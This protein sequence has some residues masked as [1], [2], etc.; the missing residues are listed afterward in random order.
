MSMT[1]RTFKV[2]SNKILKAFKES[3]EKENVGDS[4]NTLKNALL[5]YFGL[6]VDSE[7]LISK[8][9]SIHG[10][11]IVEAAA[12]AAISKPVVPKTDGITST[13]KVHDD[14]ASDSVV[15]G[16]GVK[17]TGRPLKIES[18]KPLKPNP[19]HAAFVD[20][21]LPVSDPE[22]T[23]LCDV[24]FSFD[25]TG[26]MSACRRIVRD[27]IDKVSAD[28]L[29]QFK[30]LR[31]GVMIHGDY[32]DCN[33]KDVDSPCVSLDLTKDWVSIKRFLEAPRKF[34]GG[35]EPECYEYVLYKSKSLT[36]RLNSNK[37]L[38]MIGDSIPHEPNYSMNVL[39]LNWRNEISNLKS[40]GVKII[41]VQARDVK[42]AYSF[43][44]KMASETNGHHLRLTQ[45]SQIPDIMAAICY[46]GSNQLDKFVKSDNA[47]L[48]SPAFRRNIDILDGKITEA[49]KSVSGL[50][51]FQM[52][53]IPYDVDIKSFV[54]SMG[55]R[56]EAGRGYYEFMKR[57]TV[58]S[59]KQIVVQDRKTEVF[60]PDAEGRKMLSLPNST[61]KITPKDYDDKYRFFIQ[62]TSYNRVLKKGTTF[63][64]NINGLI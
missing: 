11:D 1:E 15:K 59:Y 23:D 2:R 64:Y 48:S 50:T 13:A 21:T 9:Y 29:V 30:N 45:F 6:E 39:K 51:E 33:G 27:Y 3:I 38:V 26:S 35:D 17:P 54:T 49:S 22:S 41:S 32:Y 25:D 19:F 40:L 63:L 46:K 57:E 43:Y 12:T 47:S 52:F 28:L 5:K 7:A 16:F 56:F 61:V 8:F 44:Q 58:Q 20:A 42:S 24:V 55:L 10:K 62:S 36:W 53:D 4:I 14:I 31:V 18:T 37:I 60:Y 34:G